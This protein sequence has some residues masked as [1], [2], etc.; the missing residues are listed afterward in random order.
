MQPL[1]TL[2]PDGTGRA[3]DINDWGTIVGDA[4]DAEGN[5]PPVVCP[6][7]GKVVDLTKATV[8]PPGWIIQQARRVNNRGQIIGIGTLRISR[9]LLGS[10]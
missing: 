2:L 5:S 1:P 8:L 7:P 4:T 10:S 3:H 6:S 9:L